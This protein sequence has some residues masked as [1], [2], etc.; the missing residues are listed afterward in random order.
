VGEKIDGAVLTW[1]DIHALKR[2]LEKVQE[3]RD[4]AEAIVETV[5]EPLVVLDRNLNIKTANRSFYQTFQTLREET[6]DHLI[7]EVGDRQWDIPD[8]KKL[9]EDILPQNTSF[10]DFEIEHEFPAIGRKIMRLNARRIFQGDNG[11]QRILLAIEDITER[12]RTEE[13]LADRTVQ[14]ERTNRKLAALNAELDEFTNV[15]SHDLQEPL[16]TLIAFSDLLR[17][18][19]GDS[20]PEQ[21]AKDLAF[22]TDAAKRMQTF[23]QGLLA[24]SRT[25]RVAKKREKVSLGE[26]AE[27]ALE[28][29]AS[30]MEETGAQVTRDKLP[31]VW[32]DSTLLTELYQ[33]LIGNA[34][35]FSGE[36]R[37]II[38]LTFEELGGKQIFGVR[39]NGIGIE[40]KYAQEIFK[41]LRR[42][43]GRAEYEGSGIG[44]ATCRRIVERHGGKIW[45]ESEFGKGAHF[46]F[47]I[48]H[49]RREG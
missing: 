17:K 5:R 42:L 23:I 3:S 31:E 4:Y 9:L 20:L 24:L 35:K 16:R 22:I 27:R 18:D 40:P 33:N 7:Y 30:R 2:S 26:C 49:R 1:V 19:L 37:P 46:R 48:L 11:P 15:A 12:K 39:D 10:Q 13:A 32:G 36:Q 21:A 6:E 34:L 28:A 41:P 45:V 44:L 43:H 38:W 25:G 8:L 47:T 14:L 29:L